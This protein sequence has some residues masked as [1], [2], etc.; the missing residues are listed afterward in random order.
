MAPARLRST[1]QPNKSINNNRLE[2][3]P[4]AVTPQVTGARTW[5]VRWRR[6]RVPK[7]NKIRPIKAGETEVLA[8]FGE[9][10]RPPELW[11]LDSK[12]L[13]QRPRCI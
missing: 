7:P 13:M 4:M 8:S 6:R 5:P 11:E 10:R 3:P 2:A 9:L 12:A 1:T